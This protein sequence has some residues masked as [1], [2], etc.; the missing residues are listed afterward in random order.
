MKRPGD[1]GDAVLVRETSESLER[2]RR[3]VLDPSGLERV[4]EQT[5]LLRR[6]LDPFSRPSADL[7]SSRS[8][9]TVE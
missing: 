7:S 2:A 3:A 4:N 9:K 5:D 8:L 1:L 6:L